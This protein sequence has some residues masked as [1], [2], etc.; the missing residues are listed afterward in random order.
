MSTGK[1]V[2]APVPALMQVAGSRR[3]LPHLMSTAGNSAAG[4]SLGRLLRLMFVLFLAG[5]TLRMTI[6][7]MPPVIP[8]VH[9]ELRMSETQVG[10]L[11]GLPLAVFALAAV[12]GSLLIAWIGAPLAVLVGM[13]IAAVASGARGGAV[14]IWT[15][16]AAAIATGFG[17]AIMQ[18]GMPTLVREWL[19][20]RIALGTIAYTSGMLI[21]ATA[22]S[23][24]TI[25][26][27]L[28]A[29]RGSWR[30]DLLFWAVPALLIAPVFYL[31]S[32]R[33]GARQT[34]APATGGRWW[35]DWNKPLI[36]LLGLT[37]GSNNSTFF[38]AN[39]FIGDYLASQ[40]KSQLFGPAVGW[41]NGMQMAAPLLL[42]IM[43]DRLE[44]R[45]WPF[46]LFGP[47]LLAAFVAI[48]FA[49]SDLTIL[50]AAGLVGFTTAMT[51]APAL[52]L[53]AMLSAPTDV[54]R[55]SAG[56]FTVSYTCGI[57]VPTISGALW[58][59]TGRPWTA[60]LPMGFCAVMLTVLG[61]VVTR[62]PNPADKAAGA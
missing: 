54:A 55:N 4:P 32:P 19:P 49:Q 16:Y 8:L 36:W 47:L 31:L 45:A 29:L 12:P 15:L 9:E 38:G 2:L 25:P 37:L 20:T 22:S 27:I 5:V 6:L 53:P 58:D 41:L 7:A 18:P 23:T 24:T 44:R 33:R 17:V 62:L 11:V 61:T 35:P 48:I 60:F 40:G 14:D 43:A 52:A 46:L 3:A 39:A 26:Y 10:L 42:L 34:G 51:F 50:V 30:A 56:M 1:R 13:V 59:L 57:I 21:G 28:P